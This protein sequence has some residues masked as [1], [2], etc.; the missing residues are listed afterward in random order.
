MKHFWSL[1][2]FQNLSNLVIALVQMLHLLHE[3]LK[4]DE[5]KAEIEE[6]NKKTDGEFALSGVIW[7]HPWPKWRDLDPSVA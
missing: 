5:Q 6:S 4:Q 7:I 2:Y 1:I 3:K